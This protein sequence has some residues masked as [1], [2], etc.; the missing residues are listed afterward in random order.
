M[1][2]LR[3]TT[4]RPYK[5][6]RKQ[7]LISKVLLEGAEPLAADRSRRNPSSFQDAGMGEF[8]C[9]AIKEAKPQRGVS[10]ENTMARITLFCNS[11]QSC[12]TAWLFFDYW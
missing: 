12:E 2:N 10:L 5:Q 9:G 1:E 8:D 11:G 3:A 6:A 4:G 7:I